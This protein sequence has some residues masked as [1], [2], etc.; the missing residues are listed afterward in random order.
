[1]DVSVIIPCYNADKFIG[2][3]V[4]SVLNQTARADEIIV[5]DDGSTDS[6][7]EILRG[8]SNHVQL[9]QIA[10]TGL[11][12]SVRNV[13]IEASKG[14][15][16]AFLDADD[17]WDSR[18]LEK[19]IK[20]FQE[21]AEATLVCT[22]IRLIDEEG[23]H[24]GDSDY[25]SWT[26]SQFRSLMKNPLATL[27]QGNV[28]STSTVMVRRNKFLEAGLFVVSRELDQA[29]DYATWVKL[30]FQGGFYVIEEPLVSYRIGSSNISF[31]KVSEE[32]HRRRMAAMAELWC[33]YYCKRARLLDDTSYIMLIKRGVEAAKYRFMNIQLLDAVRMIR[34]LV[35]TVLHRLFGKRSA[36]FHAA[37]LKG[38]AGKAS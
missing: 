17:V 4:Q 6:S 14:Q 26:R 28:V 7:A 25:S 3:A 20:I 10:H 36:W 1:V 9:I 30:A 5:V 34:L 13:G 24:L 37:T 22:D 38:L 33:S 12:A 21:R 35:L 19:Q 32:V 23:R 8:V 16:I 31:Q 11:P 2:T 18:K 27:L 15:L 29:E